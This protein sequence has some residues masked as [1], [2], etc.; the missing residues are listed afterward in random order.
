MFDAK[1]ASTEYAIAYL[2]YPQKKKRKKRKKEIRYPS[3]VEVPLP[4]SS[5]MTRD[6]VVALLSMFP[7]SCSSTMNVDCPVTMSS[8]APKRVKIP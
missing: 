4:N 8:L 5:R 2:I 1:C 7:V 6:D 3:K